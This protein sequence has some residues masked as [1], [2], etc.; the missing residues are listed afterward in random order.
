M[1]RKTIISE[2]YAQYGYGSIIDN[3]MK[4][5]FAKDYNF[6]HICIDRGL[7]KIES[8]QNVKVIYIASHNRLVRKYELIS[9][10]YREAKKN[11]M[12]CYGLR[13][14]NCFLL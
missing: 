12:Q 3:Y 9:T 7:P 4:Q 11:K 8:P 14:L 1:Q 2:G 10:I 6:V 5:N 13:I